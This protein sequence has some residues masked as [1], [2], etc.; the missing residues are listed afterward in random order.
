MANRYEVS[1]IP[2]SRF[3]GPASRY[4]NSDVVY[5]GQNKIVTFSTYK[6]QPIVTSD[7][8]TF[9]SILPGEEYRPD[10]VSVRAYGVP[11]FWWKIMEYNGISDVFDFKSGVNLRIPANVF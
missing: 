4:I 7:S 6:K 2:A 1:T 3:V 11:D 5:Y 9:T 10:R 8:D